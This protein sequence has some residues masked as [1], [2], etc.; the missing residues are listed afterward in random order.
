MLETVLDT[1]E[2]P[3]PDRFGAFNE[4]VAKLVAPT[5]N[6]CERVDDFQAIVRAAGLGT[7][8]LFTLAIPEVRA[9]RSRAMIRGSDPDCYH[10]TLVTGGRHCFD[11]GD[12]QVSAGAGE[13]LLYDTSRPYTVHTH[14]HTEPA[15]CTIA[16]IPRKAL[17]LR[18]RDAE[19]IMAEP[20]SGTSGIGGLLARFMAGLTEDRG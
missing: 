9:E 15:A 8:G 3:A 2:C 16:S 7:T 5:Q 10:V 4:W 11:H 13:L 18:S 20:L 1:R 14:V 19:S 12:R 6:H 17:G